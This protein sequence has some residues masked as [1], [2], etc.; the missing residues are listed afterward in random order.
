M[1]QPVQAA[2][3]AEMVDSH[4]VT[5]GYL[6]PGQT[7]PLLVTPTN[8]GEVDLASWA[9]KNRP[10]LEGN[11]LDNGGILFRGFGAFGPDYLETFI[12]AVAG[13]PLQYKERSS[14]R[15]QVEGKIYTSTEHPPSQWIFLH[16]ENSY[17]HTWPMK[18]FFLCETAPEEQ[19]ETPIADCRKIYARIRP[20]LRQ[21]FE[22]K[23]FQI[24]RNYNTGMG[25]TWQTVFQTEDKAEVDAYC[26]EKGIETQW[27]P[28][29]GLR[30]ITRRPS[31]S[32]RHPKSGATTWFNHGTFFHVSTLEPTIRDV[33]LACMAEEDLPTNTYYGDGSPIA[34]ED[35]DH[36]R[37]CYRQEM[38]RFPWEKGDILMLDNMLTAHGRAPFKGDRKIL[39]GMAEP[40]DRQEVT[41]S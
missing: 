7:L 9:G 6:N 25:L 24:V 34:A 29:D 1:T 26:A 5:T 11:L 27:K 18:I 3:A 31:A 33:L 8:P 4:L 39:V 17:Q 30:T 37:D 36:L 32:M 28:D 35:L 12:H 2:D 23:G 10:F 16:N 13:E 15:T 21:R 22:E 38:I 19:G 40:M 41:A 14:P 20:E